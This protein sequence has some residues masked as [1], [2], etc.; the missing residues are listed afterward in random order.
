MSE[1]ETFHQILNRTDSLLHHYRDMGAINDYHVESA[2][3]DADGRAT[4]ELTINPVATLERIQ[5]EVRL[6]P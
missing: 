4:M 1:E 3:F 5:M 6:E 2:T